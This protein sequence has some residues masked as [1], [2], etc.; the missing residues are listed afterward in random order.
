LKIASLRLVSQLAQSQTSAGYFKDALLS[1]PSTRRQ[2]LQEIIRA[3]VTQDQI[4]TPT[5]SQLPPLVI[6]MP[7]QTEET[8]R[9]ISPPLA[10]T[11]VSDVSNDDNE[12]DEEEDDWD[13]FQ[14]F[15]ASASE[16]KSIE[17]VTRKHNFFDQKL[18]HKHEHNLE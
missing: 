13:T 7:S 12:E 14:S 10:A 3:S 17:C 8:K 11:I 6:K 4:S 5:K 18:E 15:P 16:P 1:M 9:Q 2:K